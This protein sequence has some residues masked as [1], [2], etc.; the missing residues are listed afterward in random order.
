MTDASTPEL[1]HTTQAQ[2]RQA[3]PSQTA[4]NPNHNTPHQSR[5]PDHSAYNYTPAPTQHKHA[6]DRRTSHCP[7]PLRSRARPHLPLCRPTSTRPRRPGFKQ[8]CKRKNIPPR[9]GAVGRHA[10]I[11]LIERF[12]RSMKYEYLRHIVVPMHITRMRQEIVC[13]IDWY[14]EHRPH[15]GLEGATPLEIN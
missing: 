1:R 11:A 12:I 14:N 5:G 3:N 10:S 2:T 15:Q 9:F 7:L 6:S 4:R 8:W 13:Y